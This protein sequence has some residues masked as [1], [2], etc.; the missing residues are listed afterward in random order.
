MRGGGWVT[1]ALRAHLQGSSSGFGVDTFVAALTEATNGVRTYINFY[2]CACYI[3]VSINI[4][5]ESARV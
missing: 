3:H 4:V 2:K 5:V 1:P